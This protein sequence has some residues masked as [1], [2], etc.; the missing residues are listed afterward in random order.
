LSASPLQHAKQTLGARLREIRVEAGLTQRD[1]ARLTGWHSSK[2]SRI[3]YGKQLPSEDD[4]KQWCLHCGTSEQTADL[5]AM[6]RA[7]DQMWMEWRRTLGTG[8]RHRQREQ[9]AMEGGTRLL[10]WYEA[11]LVPGI[12]HTPDYARGVMGKIIDFYGVAD[13]LEQGVEAR[14]ERQQILYRGD[15]RLCLLLAEQ[16]LYT[17]VTDRATMAGQLDRLLAVQGLAKVSLGII[18]RTASFE[19]LANSF[20]IFDDAK[21][22]VETIS[23]ELTITQSR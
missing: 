4:I 1:L 18:P 13:D 16:C 5:T 6:V 9:I 21:V 20:I 23:A 19:V 2:A 12:V 14:M 11:L 17:L 10:R 3:E 15:H 8:I 7:L 22:M